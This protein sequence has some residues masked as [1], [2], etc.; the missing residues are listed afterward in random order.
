[1]WLH[2]GVSLSPSLFFAGGIIGLLDDTNE[3]LVQSY[4][5][6]RGRW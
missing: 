6:I 4:K 5:I 1:M 3:I 2:G